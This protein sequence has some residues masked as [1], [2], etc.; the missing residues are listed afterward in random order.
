MVCYAE[1]SDQIK[2]VEGNSGMMPFCVTT[3]TGF[4]I[5][6][7]MKRINISTLFILVIS[8]WNPKQLKLTIKKRLNYLANL[9]ILTSNLTGD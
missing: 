2:P 1:Q 7:N 5:G 4:F 6:D 3:L 9:R 8:I